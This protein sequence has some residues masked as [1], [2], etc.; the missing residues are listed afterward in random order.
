MLGGMDSTNLR[1]IHHT[2]LACNAVINYFLENSNFHVPNLLGSKTRPN[3]IAMN[4]LLETNLER[5]ENLRGG[6]KEN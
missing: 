3:E 6:L 2:A 4:S 5:V 1:G